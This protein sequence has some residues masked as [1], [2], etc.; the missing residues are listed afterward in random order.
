MKNRGKNLGFLYLLLVLV[1]IPVTVYYL[2]SLQSKDSPKKKIL[3]AVIV[4]P[5]VIPQSQLEEIAKK[6]LLNQK[7]EYAVVVKNLKTEEIYEYNSDKKFD[8]ASLYKLWVMAVAFQK[9]KSGS[10]DEDEVL[11]APIVKLNDALFTTTPTPTPEGFSPPTPSVSEPV[12]ISMKTS[13]A[14]E[15]MITISD[16]YAAL[17]VASRSG[18]VSVA[19]FL[20]EYGLKNSNFKQPPQ[21][22]ATDIALFF[23]KLYKG[24]IVDQEYSEK[25]IAILKAQ[26]IN[27]RIPK[28]LPN[29]GVAH[30]T[31]ELF[32]S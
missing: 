30:K 1:L 23:E 27:D 14:I 17:L 10:L 2:S 24:E 18:S 20:K 3:S 6:Y 11:S 19:N 22:T 15:K 9:I 7:G 5:T 8:S 12:R 13:E 25:M 26:T 32:N 28:Y 16:N 21:T 31:G 29:I 4:L